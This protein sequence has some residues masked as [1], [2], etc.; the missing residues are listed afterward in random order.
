MLKVCRVHALRTDVESIP[1]P[2]VALFKSIIKHIK[3]VD[4]FIDT[5]KL[6]EAD[7]KVHFMI[8]RYVLVCKYLNKYLL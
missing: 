1:C 4:I 6:N 7:G 2:E 8:L 3:N 5:E